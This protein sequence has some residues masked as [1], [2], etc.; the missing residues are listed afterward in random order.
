ME[1]V[2]KDRLVATSVWL[3]AKEDHQGED[4]E[5]R[6]VLIK[7]NDYID[8]QGRKIPEKDW[9]DSVKGRV[10]EYDGKSG[11][12]KI[13]MKHF[14]Y[15]KHEAKER[16]DWFRDVNG[17]E[18]NFYEKLY[19]EEAFLRAT[20]E[21]QEGHSRGWAL[22]YGE[23][24]DSHIKNIEGLKKAK[25]FYAKLDSSI[26]EEDK[27]KI[28]MQDGAAQ[29]FG[30]PPEFIPPTTKNPL[31]IIGD[32]INSEEKSLEFARQSSASQEQQ[33]EDT[34]ETKENL[35]TPIKRLEVHGT[36][37]YAE[38]GIHAMN[39][40]KDPNNPVVVAIENLFPERFGGNIEELKWIIKKSREKMVD[41]LTNPRIQMGV[42]RQPTDM[43][44]GAPEKQ[45]NLWLPG[46]T[47]ML[48]ENPNYKG[49]GRKEAEEIAAKHIKATL[50]TGHLNMWRKYWQEDPK[51][52]KE[53]NDAKYKTWYLKQI[54]SLAKEG[55]VGN[56]H[57]ADN[58]GYQDDHTSPGQ[59]N[60]P[61]KEAVNILKKY[62]YDKA[63]TVE[64]G[65][66][67]TT[68]LSDFH[69]LMKTWRL[70]GGDV[71]GMGGGGIS[72]P[73]QQ[74]GNVQNSYFGQTNPPY[75][76]FGGYAPSNDWTLWSSVPM[77]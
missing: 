34:K 36:R 70:F 19:P 45:D 61:V 24:V 60:A 65:A 62:G 15:F 48:Q 50:D 32:L 56:V 64:P 6:S 14:D 69:G 74:W 1:T 57:L 43:T 26:P 51:I 54:E 52:S 31:A 71:S 42:S 35:I 76:V 3:R 55:M 47:G 68:D 16:N 30:I 21:N 2:Q 12:F 17:R 44:E 4:T 77:E 75:F 38:A 39:K 27:W 33:A 67:A 20:L 49:M 63:I 29:R 7:A 8:Y 66:D 22:Q 41:L 59:G 72:A 10:P 73:S 9:Y 53:Q 13:D 28:M 40:T 46:K 58:F 37:M 25:E 5:G 23:R 18:P 11:R